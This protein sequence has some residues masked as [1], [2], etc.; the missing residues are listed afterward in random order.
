MVQ[1]LYT[2]RRVEV[3]GRL[4]EVQVGGGRKKGMSVIDI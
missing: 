4:W 2:G 1:G 3:G